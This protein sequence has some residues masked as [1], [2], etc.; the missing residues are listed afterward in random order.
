MLVHA[1]LKTMQ[2]ILSFGQR[3][4][5][6]GTFLKVQTAFGGVAFRLKKIESKIRQ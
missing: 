4:L 5:V 6:L 1:L 3:V 2:Y